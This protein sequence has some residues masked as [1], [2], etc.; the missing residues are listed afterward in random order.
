MS[1]DIDIRKMAFAGFVL[2]ATPT[3]AAP[4]WV[5]DACWRYAQQVRPAL[6]YREIEAYRTNCIET[7]AHREGCLREE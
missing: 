1:H 7:E 4:Q 5:D 3:F 2:S 6:N